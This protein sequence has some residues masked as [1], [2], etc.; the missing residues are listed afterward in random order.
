MAPGA[1]LSPVAKA[2]SEEQVG[3][4]KGHVAPPSSPSAGQRRELSPSILRLA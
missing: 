2:D 1:W 4:L 3:S